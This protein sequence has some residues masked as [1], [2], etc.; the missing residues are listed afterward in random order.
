ME[1]L[2]IKGETLMFGM[3]GS[4]K[5]KTECFVD[6]ALAMRQYAGFD[7]DKVTMW[8]NTEIGDK[9]YDLLQEAAGNKKYSQVEMV[10]ATWV[11]CLSIADQ[12][13]D[14]TLSGQKLE[15]SKGLADYL[16]NHLPHNLIPHMPGTI[17]MLIKG[18]L[19]AI[20]DGL[21]K[22]GDDFSIYLN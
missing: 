20:P 16:I 10:C 5:V 3:F 7:L 2:H 12:R 19:S 4:A 14:H 15:L 8:E 21:S 18:Y 9:A 6:T 1:K 17:M 13:N 11:V 22:K